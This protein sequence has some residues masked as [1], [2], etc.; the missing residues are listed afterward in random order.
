MNA[1]RML[2]S[3]TSLGLIVL[4][5]LA[6]CREAQGEPTAIPATAVSIANETATPLPPTSTPIPPTETAAE[7]APLSQNITWLRSTHPYGHTGIMIQA[8]EQV[9]YLDPVDLVGLEEL[10]P[11]DIIFI[12]HEHPDHF[13]PPTIMALLNEN[14]KIVSMERLTDDFPDLTT[15]PLAPGEKTTVDGLEVEGIPAYNDSHRQVM[16]YLSFIFTIDGTRI[17]LSGDTELTPEM[18]ALSGIDIA[19]LN[20]RNP[21]SLTGED[22]VKFAEVV[23]PT[24]IIPIHW[25]PE[26]DTYRDQAEIEYIQQNIQEA[27]HLDVLALT[28]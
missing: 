20:V 3:V 10:P 22:V 24:T 7:G 8:E 4:L 1:R 23:N 5:F 6:G 27:T 15:F 11:A 17:Y 13:S 12:T 19:V 21:Y 25:L 9:I 16:G 14:T 26:N 18:E 2:K 28:P